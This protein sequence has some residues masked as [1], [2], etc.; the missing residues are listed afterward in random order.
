M[1]GTLFPNLHMVV[2][3]LSMSEAISLS[4]MTAWPFPSK[5][6]FSCGT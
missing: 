6:H 2:K 5:A 1:N 3:M 4:F